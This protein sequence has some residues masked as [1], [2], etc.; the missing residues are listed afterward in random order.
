MENNPLKVNSTD[1]LVVDN[2]HV[3]YDKLEV[4][5]GVSFNL[6]KADFVALIGANGAGKSTALKAVVGLL[7]PNKGEIFLEGQNITKLSTRDR[8]IAGVAYVPQGQKVFPSLSVK[9]NLQLLSEDFDH[10]LNFFP[11]LNEK[12]K[13]KA[14][15]LSG[16][17]QQ[18]LSVAR[19]MVLKPK[20]LLLDEP[21]LGLSPLYVDQIFNIFKKINKE[22]KIGI[23]V[24]EQ[25]VKKALVNAHFG[26]LLELGV[27]KQ[28]VSKKDLDN[29][30]FKKAYLGV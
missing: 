16:G 27:I 7:K 6:T 9:E 14:G 5:R 21:S 22:D 13:L 11:N 26:Y 20:F 28:K 3:S 29:S 30:E 15:S 4:L 25:N 23:L 12:L 8:L 10:I 1:G 17:E 18:M 24:V 19:A 2:I